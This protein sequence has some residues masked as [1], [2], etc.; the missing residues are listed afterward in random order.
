MFSGFPT[1]SARAIQLTWT[2]PNNNVTTQTISTTNLINGIY[3]IA[4]TNVVNLLGDS[5]SAQLFGPN[6][7][8]G[9]VAQA[10]VL[11]NDAPYFVDGRQ[12]M[13]QNLKFMIRGASDAQPFFASEFFVFGGFGLFYDQYAADMNQ[14]ATNFEQAS[15]LHHGSFDGGEDLSG[16][17]LDNLWP[18][19]I[20]YDLANYFVDTTRTN[21]FD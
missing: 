18:F 21:S 16:Y 9:Q 5:L 12:H 2:D 17:T 6:G 20:N 19:T 14:G 10:G 11:A 4:D 1:N 13:K 7:E 15:F 3:P 8:P